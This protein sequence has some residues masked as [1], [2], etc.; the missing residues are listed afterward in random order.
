MKLKQA[1]ERAGITQEE[2]AIRSNRSI[3]MIQ[4]IE[5]G[6]REG[7]MATLIALANALN[8]TPNVLLYGVDIINGTKMKKVTK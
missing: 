2:L 3:S 8:T 1:R 5:A 7:S 6:R 4:S